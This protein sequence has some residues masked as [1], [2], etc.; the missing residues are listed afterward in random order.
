[1]RSPHPYRNWTIVCVAAVLFLFG[2]GLSRTPLARAPQEDPS[3]GAPFKR[4]LERGR[5]VLA[6]E[7]LVTIESARGTAS[8]QVAEVLDVLVEAL[9]RRGRA[10]EQETRV[11]AER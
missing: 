6:S 7:L 5:E 1:M 9:F 4:D 8:L 10:K 3:E 11:L 2:G